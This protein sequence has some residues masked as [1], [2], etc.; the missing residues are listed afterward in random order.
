MRSGSQTTAISF[1]AAEGPSTT[2]GAETCADPE[3][4]GRG[5]GHQ[6]EQDGRPRDERGGAPRYHRGQG[7]LDGVNEP[8][9]A[10]NEIAR[11]NEPHEPGG[12]CY[13]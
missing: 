8:E 9:P 12:E 3:H 7:G 2:G 4:N 6:G 11:E 1:V 10:P 5:E 13:K